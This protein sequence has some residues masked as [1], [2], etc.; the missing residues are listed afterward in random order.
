[1]DNDQYKEDIALLSDSDLIE[2][3]KAVNRQLDDAKLS[4]KSYREA[5]TAC[6]NELLECVKLEMQ[7]RDL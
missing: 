7:K 5:L 3:E 2:L 1:M 6:A 4:Y